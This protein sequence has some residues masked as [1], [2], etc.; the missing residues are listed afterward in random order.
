MKLKWVLSL[1]AVFLLTVMAAPS[2][3]SKDRRL[4]S[5]RSVFDGKL[6]T[7]T[8]DPEFKNYDLN[9]R[10]Y[11][12]RRIQKRFGVELDPRAYSG[13]DLLEIEAL[14]KCKK[15]DEPFDLF[16]KMFPKTK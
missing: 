14:I 10:N 2:I 9:L 1:I 12:A 13:F 11:L 8:Q 16:L 3:F 7:G 6:F 4:P 5:E 15:S